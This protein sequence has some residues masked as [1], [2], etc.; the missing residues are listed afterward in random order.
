[1][2][3]NACVKGY[4]KAKS[5]RIPTPAPTLKMKRIDSLLSLTIALAKN[6]DT[7]GLLSDEKPARANT[8]PS[9]I[10]FDSCIPATIKTTYSSNNNKQHLLPSKL[11][12]S[13]TTSNTAILRNKT[14][15]RTSRRSMRRCSRFSH[16]LKNKRLEDVVSMR[17]HKFHI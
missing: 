8:E 17:K 5:E 3:K 9:H 15:R 16:V 12:R 1:M 2:T 6:A 13:A 11:L 7:H 4:H 14:P 10:V